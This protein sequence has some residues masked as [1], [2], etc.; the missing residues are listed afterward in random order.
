MYCKVNLNNNAKIL[1]YI[2]FKRSWN[3]SVT[4]RKQSYCNLLLLLLGSHRRCQL[5][6]RR[7]FLHTAQHQVITKSEKFNNSSPTRNKWRIWKQKWPS[8]RKPPKKQ[9]KR[10]REQKKVIHSAEVPCFVTMGTVPTLQGAPKHKEKKN[11]NI[12]KRTRSKCNSDISNSLNKN[13]VIKHEP[14]IYW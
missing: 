4:F 9:L 6:P 3:I 11:K 8:L 10:S 13:C 2:L 12:S 14:L 7:R 5:V 1:D